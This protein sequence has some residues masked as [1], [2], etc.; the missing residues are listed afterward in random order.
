MVMTILLAMALGI[1]TILF[2]QIKIT[3]ELGNSVAAFYAADTGIEWM[4]YQDEMCRRL[5]PDCNLLI[6]K[7]DCTGL[8]NQTF[9]EKYVGQSSYI[10]SVSNN[11]ATIKSIGRYKETKRAIEASR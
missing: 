7:E 2:S 10:A 1:S 9:P 6:C 4:L 3:R 8:L 11:G 5:S